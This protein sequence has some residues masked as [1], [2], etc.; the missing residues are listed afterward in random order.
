M[1]PTAE[2][3]K[4]QLIQHV[5]DNWTVDYPLTKIVYIRKIHTGEIDTFAKLEEQFRIV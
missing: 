4:E 3:S 5:I 1:K 2:Y